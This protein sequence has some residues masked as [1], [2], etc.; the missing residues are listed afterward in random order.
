MLKAV[1]RRGAGAFST[2]HAPKMSRHG[3]AIA[4]VNAFLKLL[5]SGRPSN[6]NYTTDNDCCPKVIH[7]LAN[8]RPLNIKD[9]RLSWVNLSEPQKG[10]RNLAFM[11]K[12]QREM[13]LA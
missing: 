12:I 10:Q 4:R 5:R 8:Q 6:P 7:E 2:S 13:L 9:V 11:L 3:W 1:Y